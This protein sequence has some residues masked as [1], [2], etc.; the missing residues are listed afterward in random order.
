MNKQ[1][2]N[3][4]DLVSHEMN[5]SKDQIL[6]VLEEGLAKAA[7]KGHLRNIDVRV[8]INR[9]TGEY[10]TF[11]RWQVVNGDDETLEFDPE[12]HITIEEAQKRDEHATVGGYI[13][14]P[15]PAVEFGRIDIQNAKQVIIQKVREAKRAQ[16]VETYRDKLNKLISG[17]VKRS[18]REGVSLDAGDGAEIFVSHEDLIPGE[19]LR[20]GDRVRAYLYDIR[21][22]AKGYQLFA[23]R[24]RKEILKELLWIEVPEI[25]EEVIEIKAIAR[26]PGYRSKVAVKTND[27]RIDPIG[28]CVGM[29]GA[30]IQVISNELNN[31]RIDI[32][33]WDDNP[34][35]LVINALAPAVVN[36]ILVDE[37]RHQIDVAVQEAQLAIT[38]GRNGQN[39]RLASDLT[40]WKLNVMSV[41]QADQKGQEESERLKRMFMENLDVEEDIASI[42][43]RE[44]FTSLEEIAFVSSE[45]FSPIAEFDDT[46]VAALRERAGEALV[47]QKEKG[48]RPQEDLLALE[49][50]DSDTAYALAEHDIKTLENLAEQSVDELLD[51]FPNMTE[52]RAAE[53]IMK[54]RSIVWS[55]D[56]DGGK[57]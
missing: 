50:M 4:A 15:M 51:I 26:I 57:N 27:G 8:H 5:I 24:T 45:E 13:E 34:A 56:D 30:R 44:G 19:N 10:E 25:G 46:I 53:L 2:V 7:Q 49:G 35:Q 29:R 54:A 32:I 22:Q 37:N 47:E 12:L 40:G 28:A 23:S 43:V 18:G 39:I 20:L 33:L 1:L 48:D 55:I 17:I 31:E 9:E 41:E 42:L 36:S 14:E 6:E 38:I 3:M 11:R 52:E 16:M 21:P